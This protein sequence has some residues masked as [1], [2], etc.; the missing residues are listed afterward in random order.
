MSEID[1]EVLSNKLGKIL[2]ILDIE[3]FKM[4]RLNQT[5]GIQQGLSLKMLIY[6]FFLILNCWFKE[7]KP[8]IKFGSLVCYCLYF[9]ILFPF[10]NNLQGT[11]IHTVLWYWH[12]RFT[13]FL[14]FLM[15]SFQTVIFPLV[16]I[17]SKST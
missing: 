3:I 4:L 8:W 7:N 12:Y 14:R 13:G 16:L 6:I 17:L 5:Y 11:L 10:L 15:Q 1:Y 2:Q 9:R